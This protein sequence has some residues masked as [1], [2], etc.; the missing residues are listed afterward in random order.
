MSG[1]VV[2]HNVLSMFSNR[3]LGIVDDRKTKS[4][5]KL[6]SGY[7]INRAADDAAGLS[8]SEKMRRQIRGLSQASDN[9]Q[10]G[11]SF[12]QIGDGAM[13]EIHAMLHRMEELSVKA[14]NGTMSES[15][16]NDIQNEIDEIR[17]EIDRVTTTT[18]FNEMPVFGLERT[19]LVYDTSDP[20]TQR[21]ISSESYWVE[22]NKYGI[23]EVLGNNHIFDGDKLTSPLKFSGSDWRST[24]QVKYSPGYKNYSNVLAAINSITGKDFSAVSSDFSNGINERKHIWDVDSD[25]NGYYYCLTLTPGDMK[26]ASGN[27]V[28]TDIKIQ[29]SIATNHTASLEESDTLKSWSLITNSVGTMGMSGNTYASAWL[30]F[31]GLGTDYTVDSLYGQGF[32]STCASC[33]GHYSFLFTDDS[34]GSDYEVSGN[35]G[36]DGNVVLKVNISGCSSGE[37]VVKKLMEAANSKLFSDHYQQY[38]YNTTEPSKLYIYD[39]RTYKYPDGGKSTFEPIARNE[40][41]KWI[42]T[43]TVVNKPSGEQIKYIDK[44]IWI[45][46]GNE[47][48]EGFYIIR[49]QANCRFLG[50]DGIDMTNV[51]GA[52]DS[53]SSISNAIAIL[54]EQRTMV[55]AQQ[56]RCEYS[57]KVDDNSVEN[58]TA[59][60]S[61]IR[62]TDMATE[63]VK[64]SKESILQQAGQAMLAQ[65]NQQPQS[66]LQLLQ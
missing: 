33:S 21:I 17:T 12:N 13:E 62:D 41:G 20:G 46:A 39:D 29:K 43:E 52:R 65:A 18:V 57:I 54:N 2:A 1:M 4:S 10:D 9:C 61:R 28:Y 53:L 14:S 50:I 56:N 15:D 40:E 58:T 3:S 36:T 42:K 8:I 6:G 35:S 55:G 45:Q 66:I 34:L 38:A 44:N 19:K 22:G 30:D 47:N 48:T 63:M 11:V 16:R 60:E 24:G 51:E 27:T 25:G 7:K 26:D 37:D 32:N 49:P 59:S 64:Y 23:T 31:S 5:E